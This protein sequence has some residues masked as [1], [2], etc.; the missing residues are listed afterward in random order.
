MIF[1]LAALA[2]TVLYLVYTKTQEEYLAQDPVIQRLVWKL[3]PVFPELKRVKVLRSPTTSYTLNKYRVYLCVRNK[4]TK[5]ILSDNVLTYVLLHEL[6]HAL[7]VNY[8]HGSTYQ[9]IFR[10]LLNRA[11]RN[12]LYKHTYIPTNY[13]EDPHFPDKKGQPQGQPQSHPQD[14]NQTSGHPYWPLLPGYH[15]EPTTA[16][17]WPRS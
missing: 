9:S 4:V 17:L 8:G 15:R 7:N 13:C 16:S 5:R 10:S 2:L 3:S 6:A 11:V 1:Y 12:K 14:Q